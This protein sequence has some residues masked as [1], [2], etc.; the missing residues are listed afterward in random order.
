MSV[1]DKY[2]M[3]TF[4]PVH[5]PSVRQMVFVYD[6]VWITRVPSHWIEGEH[7]FICDSRTRHVIGLQQGLMF[8][9]IDDAAKAG[10]MLNDCIHYRSI[11]TSKAFKCPVELDVELRVIAVEC[12][13]HRHC[14]VAVHEL[15]MEYQRLKAI[16]EGSSG[17]K[18]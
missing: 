18:H 16:D 4:S 6:L 13:A 3:E 15:M 17:I 1:I 9:N 7:W 12:D 2:R 11:D 8:G 5:D 10:A 14:A